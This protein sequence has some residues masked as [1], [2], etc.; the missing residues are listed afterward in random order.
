MN[1]WGFWEAEKKI[2]SNNLSLQSCGDTVLVFLYLSL[3]A[4]RLRIWEDGR[5]NGSSGGVGV[6]ARGRRVW[7]KRWIM[8]LRIMSKKLHKAFSQITY[9]LGGWHH[10]WSISSVLDPVPHRS[11]VQVHV[12]P[13][14][15]V[16]I[17]SHS[18]PLAANTAANVFLSVSFCPSLPPSLTYSSFF[19][20]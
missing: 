6:A 18:I 13:P 4:S 10:P 1:K 8:W 17:H 16:H 20:I 15:R 12:R 2:T 14:T 11:A 19:G 7:R 9:H 3:S 5:E